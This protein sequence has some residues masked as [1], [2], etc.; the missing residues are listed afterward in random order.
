VAKTVH[1][2]TLGKK[3]RH[4]R[5]VG[6]SDKLLS[7]AGHYKGKRRLDYLFGKKSVPAD[8]L[9]DREAAK[10][11]MHHAAQFSGLW[12]THLKQVFVNPGSFCDVVTREFKMAGFEDVE[13]L[14]NEFAWHVA[15]P[16][17]DGYHHGSKR[18]DDASCMAM[19]EDG[20]FVLVA[21]RFSQERWSV[22]TQTVISTPA[23]LAAAFKKYPIAR[24]VLLGAFFP[25]VMELYTPK[26]KHM[27]RSIIDFEAELA[28]VA[29]K[30]VF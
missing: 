23:Q 21:C 5:L 8:S 29:R 26:L 27:L 10:L 3:L 28:Q 6:G 13:D 30:L 7:S 4:V 15:V 20:R 1:L 12:C 17:P 11:V 9:S 14:Y 19:L 24:R 25:H 16:D 2:K 22:E 18:I